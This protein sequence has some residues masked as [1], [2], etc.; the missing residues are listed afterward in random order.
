MIPAPQLGWMAGIIDLKGRLLRKNNQRRATSQIVLAV[1]S[2][3][4][5]I[6]RGLSRLTGTSPEMQERRPLREW[7]RTG[8]TEHCPEPHVHVSRDGLF[9]PHMAR[10]TITG[11]A[12]VVILDNVLPFLMVDRGYREA[13]A[14]VVANTKFVGQGSGATVAALQRLKDLGW[15]MPKPFEG[16]MSLPRMRALEATLVTTE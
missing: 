13:M 12:M 15:E 3:E 11:A 6:V 14:E 7:M 16:P 10:W 2:K 9:M 8:C 5:A 1:E 4:V